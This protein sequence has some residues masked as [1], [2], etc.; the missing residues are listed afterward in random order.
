MN[1]T[2]ET[3]WFWFV[4]AGLSGYLIGSVSVTRIM[5]RLLSG[6]KE[7]DSSQF[8]FHSATYVG[9]KYGKKYGCITSVLDMIKVTIPTL[10]FRLLFPEQIH[11]LITALFAIIG[12]NY[13]VYYRFKGGAGYSALLGAVF[14]INWFGVFVANG[15]AMILGYFLGNVI[16]MRVA[17]NILYI[18]WF[19][20]YF[21]DIYHVGFI[22]LA[23][24][25]F[26]VSVTRQ[27]M[28]I[29]GLER[30]DGKEVNQEYMARR[31]L[32]GGKFGKFIDEYGFPALI[33]KLYKK[34]VSK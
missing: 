15:A 1:I 19:W 5:F 34:I 21:N 12:N 32:M 14:V 8:P 25:V 23:N 2:I 9:K 28:R 13:P 31:I 18:I 33:R 30:E 16:V 22:I 3:S 17:G 10:L 4:L 7:I 24:V 20:I 11:Y 27:L 6:R 26:F 29:R